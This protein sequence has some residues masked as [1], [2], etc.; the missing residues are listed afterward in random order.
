MVSDPVRIPRH[1][2]AEF[3]TRLR[4]ISFGWGTIVKETEGDA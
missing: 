4:E 1:R 2:V 3:E